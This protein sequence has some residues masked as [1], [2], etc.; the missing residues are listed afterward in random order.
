MEKFNKLIDGLKS[1]YSQK[2]PFAEDYLLMNSKDQHNLCRGLRDELIK[3]LYSNEM[4]FQN[5]VLER[6]NDI[7]S[8]Y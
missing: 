4:L 2:A 1:C 7:R 6:Y 3:H 5:I 8:K